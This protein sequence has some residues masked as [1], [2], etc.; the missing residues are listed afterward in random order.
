MRPTDTVTTQNS[1]ARRRQLLIGIA[2][3]IL[4]STSGVA[5]VVSG[6][7][8]FRPLDD[9]VQMRAETAN[10]VSGN[11][12]G[13]RCA[14]CGVVASAGPSEKAGAGNGTYVAVRM[15]D[16]SSRSFHD[17]SP[18]KWRPGERVIVIN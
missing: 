4:L 14:E 1:E 11:P 9:D 10:R 5:A 12:A 7:D 2:A 6:S 18:A 8:S 17:A 13:M 15:A 16:G 3:A